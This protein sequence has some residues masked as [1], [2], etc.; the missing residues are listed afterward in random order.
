MSYKSTYKTKINLP[1]RTH[2]EQRKVFPLPFPTCPGEHMLW[3]LKPWQTR[4]R[5]NLGFAKPL[6]GQVHGAGDEWDGGHQP[7]SSAHNADALL[8][9]GK[10]RFEVPAQRNAIAS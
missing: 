6:L 7:L 5:V 1:Y 2:G 8:L 9:A 4:D 3:L 10:P